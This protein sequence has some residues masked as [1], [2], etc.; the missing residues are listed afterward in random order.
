MF[1]TLLVIGGSIG[2]LLTLCAGEA[3]K[4][5]SSKAGT[6]SSLYGFV[7]HSGASLIGFA[8]SILVGG[9]MHSMTVGLFLLALLSLLIRF[10]IKGDDD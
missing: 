2:I 1:P 6:A 4:P 3:I 5:F 10:I 9:Q 8:L 7:Q